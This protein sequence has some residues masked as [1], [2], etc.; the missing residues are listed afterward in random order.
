MRLN[1]NISEITAEK[2]T[3]EVVKAPTHTL[4]LVNPIFNT[5]ID[6]LLHILVATHEF[7]VR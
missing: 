2:L 3:G 4:Y 1:M 6:A 5:E 7:E